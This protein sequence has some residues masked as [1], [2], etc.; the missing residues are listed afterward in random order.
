L[1][2]NHRH[3]CAFDPEAEP[4]VELSFGTT[5]AEWRNACDL[6]ET[7]TLGIALNEMW[8]LALSEDAWRSALAPPA[9]RTLRDVCLLVAGNAERLLVEPSGAL[10]A[11]SAAA[12]AFLAVRGLL[13]RAGAEGSGIRP[14]APIGEIARRFPHVFL[15]PISQLAPDRLPTVSVTSSWQNRLAS[16]ITALGFFGL[17]TAYFGGLTIFLW[18]VLLLA[19]GYLGLRLAARIPP[20][21]V[22]FG[23]IETFRDLAE[24]LSAQ[25]PA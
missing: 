1:Q 13:L 4:D 6:V 15:G 18:S 23:S 20:K 16:S 21:A 2:A 19:V 9:T 10:G 7:D 14:S 3:Q 8:G 24:A 12:G 5:V 17:I 22:H 11:K 25:R